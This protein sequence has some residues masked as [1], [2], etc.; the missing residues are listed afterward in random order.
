MNTPHLH[1]THIY[2]LRSTYDHTLRRTCD[3]VEDLLELGD[4]KTKWVWWGLSGA[5][6]NVAFSSHAYTFGSPLRVPSKASRP[7]TQ[8]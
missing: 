7:L 2:L 5:P 6:V 1:S 3:V 8:P 4:L